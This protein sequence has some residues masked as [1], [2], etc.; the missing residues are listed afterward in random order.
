MERQSASLIETYD[1]ALP[2]AMVL[3]RLREDQSISV[4]DILRQVPELTWAQM[5]IAID[6]LNR[7]GDIEVRR[8]G[9]THT[10]RRINASKHRA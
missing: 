9:F 4:E 1:R 5:F 7:R 3:D 8:E 6:I 10:V 2:E